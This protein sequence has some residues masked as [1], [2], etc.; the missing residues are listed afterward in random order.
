MPEVEVSERVAL[1]PGRAWAIISDLSRLGEWLSLHEDWRSEVPAEL[2]AGTQLTS[3]VAVKGFRNRVDWT[4]TELQPPERIVLSGDGKAGT[5]VSLSAGARADGDEARIE[6]RTE[7]SNPALVG[8]IGG[9]VARSLRG[10]LK[11]AIDRL[12]ELA[13]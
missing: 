1:D 9:M 7:F 4:I 6:L 3:I 2:T 13:R 8:P 10:E 5:K 11:K 12:A